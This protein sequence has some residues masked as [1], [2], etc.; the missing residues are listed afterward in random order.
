MLQEGLDVYL[1][2]VDNKGIDAVVRRPDGSFTEV[3]IKARAK[4]VQ[5]GNAA[6]FTAGFDGR[7]NYWFVFYAER[8]DALLIL[9]AGEF[10]PGSRSKHRRQKQRL[11][12]HCL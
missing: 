3:Q 6:L 8:L 1:P 9:S 7:E 12:D 5:F 2:A 10:M 11:V 4:D